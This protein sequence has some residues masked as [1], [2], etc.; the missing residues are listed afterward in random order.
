MCKVSELERLGV[1]R[2]VL[3]SIILLPL[4]LSSLQTET[5]LFL[6]PIFNVAYTLGATK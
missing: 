5:K 2:T 6:K 1:E 3:Y 4:A